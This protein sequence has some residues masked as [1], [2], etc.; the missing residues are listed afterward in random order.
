MF[1]KREHQKAVIPFITKALLRGDGPLEERTRMGGRRI[2]VSKCNLSM[3]GTTAPEWFPTAMPEE[4]YS[5]GLMSRYFTCYLADRDVH[6]IDL[7]AQGDYEHIW[8]GMASELLEL[9]KAMPDGQM[10]VDK[11]ANK[12]VQEWYPTNQKEV[13][14]DARMAPHIERRPANMT[15]LAMLLACSAGEQAI[16]KNRLEQALDIIKWIEPTIFNMYDATDEMQS[17]M[18]KGELRILGEFARNGGEVDHKKLCRSVSKHFD[19]GMKEVKLALEGLEEKEFIERVG[20]AFM[21]PNVWPP[22]AWRLKR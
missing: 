5:G 13:V 3:I 16:T 10:M 17:Y 20:Q 6:C 9:T 8:V 1:G 4:A 15:R 7:E 11:E 22:R 18:S 14:S 21:S 12:W 2:T 19:R